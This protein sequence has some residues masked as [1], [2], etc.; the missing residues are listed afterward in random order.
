MFSSNKHTRLAPPYVG[1]PARGT[2]WFS[3]PINAETRLT[4]VLIP[5]AAYISAEMQSELGRLPPVFLPIGNTWLLKEQLLCLEDLATRIVLTLPQDYAASSS[6]KMFL[7]DHAIDVHGLPDQQSLGESIVWALNVAGV[8]DEPLIILHGDTYVSHLSSL[9]DDNFGVSRPQVETAWDTLSPQKP[10]KSH[11]QAEPDT[12]VVCGAFRFSSASGLITSIL[13]SGGNFIA[14]LDLYSREVADFRPVEMDRWLDFGHLNAFYNSRRQV[15]TERAFNSV[16]MGRL[17][18]KKS[19]DQSAKMAAEAHWFA[20]IPGPLK[21]YTPAFVGTIKDADGNIR[22]Y[23][24]E[25][26]Y[27]LPLADL[28]VFSRIG[29]ISWRQILKSCGE[30]LSACTDVEVPKID[31]KQIEALYLKKT[32]D[33]LRQYQDQT[34]FDIAHPI[35]V[36]GKA[37]PSALEMAEKACAVLKRHKPLFG[38]SHG[39]F[40]FSN[41][42]YDFK[43]QRI[44]L[45]DPRGHLEQ[46]APFIFGDIRYDLAKLAH[47]ILG[48][49]DYIV[50]D[51]YSF[52]QQSQYEFSLEI[53]DVPVAETLTAMFEDTTF[54]GISPKRADIRA[55]TVLLFLSMLP[56]HSDRKDRQTAFLA[57]AGRLFSE[58]ELAGQ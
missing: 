8:R 35:V 4:T 47:S 50:A 53:E 33:R 44:K 51:H 27:N 16:K 21:I 3:F 38:V 54:G 49:Y 48:R 25:T 23:E 28:L 32:V 18:T 37:L 10:A 26:L 7:N 57:N 42:L 5:S 13:G 24:T 9:Q 2:R 12:K 15:S 22:G 6:Q 20:S 19:S 31:A 43:A 14:A 11:P 17:T 52:N 34:G 56:L 29:V 1:V 46:D 55:I 40:C 58:F 45:I 30:F 39:D 36:N 41:I